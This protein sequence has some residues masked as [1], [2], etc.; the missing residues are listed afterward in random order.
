MSSKSIVLEMD[1]VPGDYEQTVD[2]L[3]QNSLIFCTS[4]CNQG[5]RMSDGKPVDHE[6][7]I[8]PVAALKAERD[9]RHE[10]ALELLR[11]D[12]PTRRVHRGVKTKPDA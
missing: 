5:H 4:F 3:K 8:L 9:G 6:C 7:Y 10:E 1:W 2:R 11:A 12:I